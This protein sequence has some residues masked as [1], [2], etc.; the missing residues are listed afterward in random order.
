[1][2]YFRGHLEGSGYYDSSRSIQRINSTFSGSSDNYFAIPITTLCITHLNQPSPLPTPYTD[3]LLAHA[4]LPLSKKARAKSQTPYQI[5][6][7]AVRSFLV[8]TQQCTVED[9]ETLLMD[10]PR[11][12]ERHSDL[13]VLSEDSFSDSRWQKHLQM[14]KEEIIVPISEEMPLEQNPQPDDCGITMK[15]I[16]EGTTSS[17]LN[18]ITVALNCRRLGIGRSITCDSYRS[19]GASLLL[20][21]DGWVEHVDNGV[22]YVFDVTKCM[23]SSGNISEKLRVASFNCKGETVVDLYA[24]IGY[25]TL[26][27]LVHTGA[28]IVHACE[29][30][31]HAVE[32]LERGLRANN[33]HDRCVIHHGDNQKVCVLSVFTII[34][35]VLKLTKMFAERTS[36]TKIQDIIIILLQVYYMLC[37]AT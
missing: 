4:Q 21:D 32:A 19:S 36:Q 8:D 20:G 15:A 24:G 26:P 6:R 5:L 33:V 34:E 16:T 28:A 13:V 35:Q 27:Y 7:E 10:V 11:S 31:S 3:C 14:V 23:F 1:M 22:R 30:N 2:L 9:I 25:F 17:L 18:A 29:W 37:I 12:W